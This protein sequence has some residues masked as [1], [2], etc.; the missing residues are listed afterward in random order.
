MNK[1]LAGVAMAAALALTTTAANAVPILTFGEAI[2]GQTPITATV[3]GGV[4]TIS[5]VN[6]QVSVTSIIGNPILISPQF[7]N[8]TATS[9]GT[10][11]N[12]GG[13]VTEHFTGN[14]SITA[15]AQNILS[16]TFSDAVFGSGTALTLS[17]SNATPGQLVTFTSNVI[18]PSALG[19]PL[20]IAL[21][22]AGVT[23]PANTQAPVGCNGTAGCTISPFT[24]SVAGTFS[25]EPVGVP[26]PASLAL[27]GSALAGLGVFGW[28]RRK[29]A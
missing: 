7:L 28:R 11:T 16:G 29:A 9:F 10:A 8:L 13:V 24:S 25:A 6:A 17:A 14:F 12:V 2:A 5:T 23:P 15:G 1:P 3:A 22:F 21:S 18:S 4:T 19:N 20:G 27:L 26:E